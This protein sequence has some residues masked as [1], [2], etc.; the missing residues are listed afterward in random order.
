MRLYT[1]ALMNACLQRADRIKY[2]AIYHLTNV[3]GCYVIAPLYEWEAVFLGRGGGWVPVST[4]DAPA[5][6]AVI[7]MPATLV[8]ELMTAHRGPQAVGCSVECGTFSSPGVGNMPAFD[9]VPLVSA[10]ATLD[11]DAKSLYLSIVNC[12]V[13]AP[14]RIDLAGIDCEKE[15]DVYCVAGAS[16]L[17]T[18][19]FDAPDTI[20]ITRDK[21][22]V[23]ELTLPP[24]SFS[25]VV[26][27]LD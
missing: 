25:L 4:G 18:N 8:L 27:R 21:A 14:M 17:A 7:K 22:R 3:M 26:L 16:P 11:A 2:S 9:A 13:D 12:S 20:T 10:A 24:H 1:G 5:A 6:P 19:S 23:G 15:A